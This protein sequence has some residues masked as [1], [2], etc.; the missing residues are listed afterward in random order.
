M[1]KAVY[2]AEQIHQFY[3]RIDLPER[4]RYEPGDESRAIS[5]GERGLELLSALQR[6]SLAHIPFENLSL[7]YSRTKTID[8]H[9]TLLFRK[10][11]SD[12]KGR[13]G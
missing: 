10:I 6:F 11:V 9:P 8:L 13:G 7:H 5:Q 2:S 12:G 3:G 1:G 4:Y